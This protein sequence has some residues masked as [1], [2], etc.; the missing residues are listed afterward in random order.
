MFDDIIKKKKEKKDISSENGCF[1][2]IWRTKQSR[3]KHRKQ[4]YG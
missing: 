2:A 4:K 3:K 1:R